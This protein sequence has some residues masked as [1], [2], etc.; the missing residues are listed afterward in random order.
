MNSDIHRADN[1][2]RN[3]IIAIYRMKKAIQVGE[4]IHQQHDYLYIILTQLHP[5]SKFIKLHEHPIAE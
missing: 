2:T 4:C 1:L 3:I 5:F